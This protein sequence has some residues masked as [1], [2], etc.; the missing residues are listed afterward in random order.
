MPEPKKTGSPAVRQMFAS[1]AGRYDLL[2]RLFSL[3]ADVRW[4][5]QLAAEVPKTEDL[6]LLDV[7]TG[8]AD[9]ALALEERCPGQGLIVG[10]DFTLPM[11][12]V[13]AGKVAASG[14]RRIRMAAGDAY[15][16]PFRDGTFGAVTISFG[17][18]N[19]AHRPEALREMARVLAPGGRAVILEFSPAHKPVLGPLFRFYFHTAVMPWI[20]GIVSGNPGA[21]RYLPE[22]VQQFPGTKELAEE[23]TEAGFTKVTYR[24]LAM[25]IAYLHMGEKA[26][27]S[28]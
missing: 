15:S 22:S 16:L 7:A 6:P 21:Y 5:R 10:V 26:A 19:L 8:T 3:G 17:L 11:L 28:I 27:S 14:A 23:M 4:R 24:A 18:R 2:N 25:G 12:Q 9:V 20:G 1:I 13:G